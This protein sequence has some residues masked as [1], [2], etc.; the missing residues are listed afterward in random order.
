ASLNT[1][2]LLCLA[3]GEGSFAGL[4][5]GLELGAEAVACLAG[6]YDLANAS[7]DETFIFSGRFRQHPVA[8]NIPNIHR[9]YAQADKPPRALLIYGDRFRPDALEAQYLAGLPSVTLAPIANW[10]SHFIFTAL[11]RGGGVDGVIDWLLTGV[12]PRFESADQA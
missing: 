4:Q 3:S 9:L 10:Q 7:A 5:Y 12:I 11:L 8:R 6:R 2:R 1:K